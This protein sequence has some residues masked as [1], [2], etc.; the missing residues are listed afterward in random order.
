MSLY[1]NVRRDKTLMAGLVILVVIVGLTVISATDLRLLTSYS[2]YSLN[3]SASNLPPSAKHIFGT[4]QEGRDVFTRVLAALPVDILT[5]FIIVV[6]SV[7]LGGLVG[8]VAGYLAGLVDEFLMRITDLFLA[9]PGILLALAITE[10]LGQSHVSLRLL[11]SEVALIVVGWPVYARLAR[12]Q[13]LQVKNMPYVTLAKVSGLS[14]TQILRRHVLPHLLPLLLVYSTLDMGAVILNYSV[15]AF[16]GL[17]APP[18]T[19]EL[20]RMVY[21][22]LSALPQN[23]WSSLFPALIITIMAVSFSL[24]G[25]GLRDA[26]DPRM[27]ERYARA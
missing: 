21:D 25:D 5:P 18:P 12:G 27:G 2:P 7:L 20:G 15:L 4:D 26:L 8:V 6:A 16:F 14:R 22:G 9:F 19:P 17:G 11:Y 13:V 10:I 24:M 1:R 23:W 3:F